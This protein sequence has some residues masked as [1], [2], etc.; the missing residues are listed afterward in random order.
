MRVI[1]LNEISDFKI[2]SFVIRHVDVY[3]NHISLMTS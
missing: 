3:D 1:K 2:L